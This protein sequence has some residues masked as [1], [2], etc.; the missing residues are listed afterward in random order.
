M[1]Y[2]EHIQSLVSDA[3]IKHVLGYNAWRMRFTSTFVW[4]NSGY[5][6]PKTCYQSVS[7]A[8]SKENPLYSVDAVTV[9]M[10]S[11]M[12]RQMPPSIPNLW[13]VFYALKVKPKKTAH[14]R[15]RLHAFASF[16]KWTRS[17]N[18]RFPAE[19]TPHVKLK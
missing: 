8:V 5:F 15:E 11:G 13:N 1:F 2:S 4:S 18:A 14:I 19:T 3:N 12:S 9:H 6:Q 16:S 17:Q 7:E 10:G